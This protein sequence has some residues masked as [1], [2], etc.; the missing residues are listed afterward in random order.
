MRPSFPHKWNDETFFSPDTHPPIAVEVTPIYSPPTFPLFIHT[1]TDIKWSDSACKWTAKFQPRKSFACWN[2]ALPTIKG[3]PSV[4]D[5]KIRFQDELLA[6]RIAPRPGRFRGENSSQPD[7][8][9]LKKRGGAPPNLS[10][11]SPR[12]VSAF[13]CALRPEVCRLLLS[14]IFFLGLSRPKRFPKAIDLPFSRLFDRFWTCSLVNFELSNIDA[15]RNFKRL[16][17]CAFCDFG[18]CWSN[19]TADYFINVTVY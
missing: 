8:K 12:F 14:R 11:Y 19:Q 6:S 4:D 15:N 17:T 16:D 9:V 5:S 10:T 18:C 1:C 2:S 3:S 13:H 7:E